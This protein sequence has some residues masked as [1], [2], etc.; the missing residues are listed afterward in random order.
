M[1]TEARASPL[2]PAERRSFV[3]HPARLHRV[4][5][6]LREVVSADRQRRADELHEPQQCR[7]GHSS[8]GAH[9]VSVVVVMTVVQQHAET[10]SVLVRAV[11]MPVGAGLRLEG[12]LLNGNDEAQPAHHVVEHMIVPIAQPACRQSAPA[13]AD[14]RGDIPH[15]PVVCRRL[16]GL[17]TRFRALRRLR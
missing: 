15:A 5:Q 7:R 6:A 11:R 12:S 10:S 17:S 1:P 8:L 4:L 13:R 14:C 16:R 9:D 3:A 2:N